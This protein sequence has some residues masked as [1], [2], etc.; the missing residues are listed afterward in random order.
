MTNGLKLIYVFIY[1][2]GGVAKIPIIFV[3]FCFL[4]FG[5]FSKRERVSKH[6]PLKIRVSCRSA[7]H[8]INSSV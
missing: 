3:F 6:D 4:F 8:S 7:E 1:F 5:R 2:G